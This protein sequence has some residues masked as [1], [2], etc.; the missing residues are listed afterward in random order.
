MRLVALL[1]ANASLV[2]FSIAVLSACGNPLHT[3][4]GRIV[5]PRICALA[6]GGAM[7]VSRRFSFLRDV[8]MSP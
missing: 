6:V 7:D 3:V 5:L 8:V 4:V 2:G 1:V